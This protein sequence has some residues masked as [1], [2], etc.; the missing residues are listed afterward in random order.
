MTKQDNPIFDQDAFKSEHKLLMNRFKNPQP[1]KLTITKILN[2]T[3][4]LKALKGIY[5]R[6]SLNELLKKINNLPYEDEL[7]HDED[8]IKEYLDGN[9]EY[10]YSRTPADCGNCTPPWETQ[11]YIDAENWMKTLPEED[12]AKIK[13]LVRGNVP[14]A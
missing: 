10:L 5:Y 7:L 8:V 2:R 14:W 3:G 9:A 13:I 6:D 4:L 12:Q 1:K 11:E